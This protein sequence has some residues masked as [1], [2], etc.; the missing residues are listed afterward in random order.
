ML[1]L[2]ICPYC[3]TVYSYSEVRKIAGEKSHT[4]YHCKKQFKA[5]KKPCVVLVLVL[6]VLAVAANVGVLYMA[7]NLNFYVLVGINV[8]FILLFIAL[9][10]LFIAFKDTEKK[11]KKQK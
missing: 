6:L 3:H 4:C 11:Q 5:S 8:F 2:P 10:P 1:K 7:P 9:Y